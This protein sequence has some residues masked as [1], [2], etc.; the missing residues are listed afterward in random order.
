MQLLAARNV[1]QASAGLGALTVEH[2]RDMHRLMLALHADM[3][4]DN[5]SPPSLSTVSMASE[6]ATLVLAIAQAQRYYGQDGNVLHGLSL[7]MGLLADP[8]F[9][10][11]PSRIQTLGCVCYLIAAKL[12]ANDTPIRRIGYR[13]YRDRHATVAWLPNVSRVLD[14]ERLILNHYGHLIPAVDV[15]S[16]YDLA[17]TPDLLSLLVV[18]PSVIFATIEEAHAGVHKALVQWKEERAKEDVDDEKNRPNFTTIVEQHLLLAQQMRILNRVLVHPARAVEFVLFAPA[19]RAF[20]LDALRNGRVPDD[21][22]VAQWM[23][24]HAARMSLLSS[25]Q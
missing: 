4:Y 17:D 21:T 5:R 2:L 22:D 11:K 10:L 18:S 1:V 25:F 3:I 13:H 12:D 23:I 24:R 9:A 19:E 16:L 14:A 6:P 20:L 8:C 15:A 7:A